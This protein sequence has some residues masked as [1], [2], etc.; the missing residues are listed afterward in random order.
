MNV[1]VQKEFAK[2]VALVQR[3]IDGKIKSLPILSHFLVQA[4]AEQQVIVT[5]TDL[6]TSI[7]LTVP[8]EVTTPGSVVLPGQKLA[9]I[10]HAMPP[11]AKVTLAVENDDNVQLTCERSKFRLRTAPVANFPHSRRCRKPR[12]SPCRRP[13]SRTL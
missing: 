6:T 9:D 1:T 4:T 8:A 10:T 13:P 7:Q 3:A 11:T 12:G 5:G 2:A